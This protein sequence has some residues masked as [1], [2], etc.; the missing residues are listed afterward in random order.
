MSHDVNDYSGLSDPQV[1]LKKAAIEALRLMDVMPE[2]A[3]WRHDYNYSWRYQTFGVVLP[4]W[5]VSPMQA[6]ATFAA[7]LACVVNEA[8]RDE[9]NPI[10]QFDPVDI[11]RQM[12]VDNMGTSLIVFW[13]R[14][15]TDVG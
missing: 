2:E 15:R 11:V 7:A 10:G 6:V 12:S 13:P 14:Y 3:E 9:D 4:A 8:D 1:V 5:G